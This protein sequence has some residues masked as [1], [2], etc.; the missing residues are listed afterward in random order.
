MNFDPSTRPPGTRR[1]RKGRRPTRWATT[2]WDRPLADPDF[3]LRSVRASGVIR[4]EFRPGS[5]LYLVWNENRAASLGFGDFRLRRDLQG[6]STAP[7]HD[8]LL[9]KVSY[10]LPV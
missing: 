6:I 8:V 4:W 5:A 2:H 7:S 1:D 10:W 3:N 9:S